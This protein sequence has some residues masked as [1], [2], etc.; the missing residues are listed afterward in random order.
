[1]CRLV[2]ADTSE[3]MSVNIETIEAVKALCTLKFYTDTPHLIS[4]LG[5]LHF[6]Y[7]GSRYW[8]CNCTIPKPLRVR[9]AWVIFEAFR[10]IS[11][12]DCHLSGSKEGQE[13]ADKNILASC[14]IER[15][16]DAP[17]ECKY[18]DNLQQSMEYAVSASPHSN[19]NTSEL[20]E[21]SRNTGRM[22]LMVVWAPMP[23]WRELVG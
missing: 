3:K 23:G 22:R 11:I 16:S 10:K 5:N 13:Y 2:S 9:D 20:Y 19:I 14:W 4:N 17:K 15:Y 6:D 21:V 18:W 12:T 8:V 7:N 1:M